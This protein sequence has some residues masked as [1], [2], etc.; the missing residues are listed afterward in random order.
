MMIGDCHVA[1]MRRTPKWA[2]S[3]QRR[4]DTDGDGW[5]VRR[6]VE[7]RA[8][9]I[10]GKGALHNRIQVRISSAS[11]EAASHWIFEFRLCSLGAE[12]LGVHCGAK[13]RSCEKGIRDGLSDP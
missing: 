6:S 3:N 12:R 11:D 1:T 13:L 9:R 10:A 5:E 8:K 4:K 2:S 7:A